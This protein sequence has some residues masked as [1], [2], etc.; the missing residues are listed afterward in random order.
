MRA[1]W[2]VLLI[3]CY[4]GDKTNKN[5][6]GGACSM[7]EKGEVHMVFWWRDHVEDVCIDGRILFKWIFKK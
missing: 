1:S 3:K 4:L 7:W 2:S 5:M 6:M